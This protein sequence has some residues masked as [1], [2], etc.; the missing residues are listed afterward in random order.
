M[1]KIE[2]NME[3]APHIENLFREKMKEKHHDD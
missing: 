1:L 2:I 3:F